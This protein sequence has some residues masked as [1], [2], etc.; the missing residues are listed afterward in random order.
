MIDDPGGAARPRGECAESRLERVLR[1]GAFAVTAETVP[2]LS[3]DANAVLEVAAPLR[4]LVDAVN[5]T[6]GAGARV[7]LSALAAAAILAREGIEPVLQFTCRD[8]NRLALQADLL[9]AAALGVR[10]VLCLR[11]DDPSAGDQP[12]AKAVFDLDSAELIATAAAMR[13]AGR[14]PSGRAIEAPPRFFIGAVDT[15]IDP[16]PDWSPDSLRNKLDRGADFVQTQLCFD[17]HVIER[18]IGRLRDEGLTERLFILVGL[19]PISSARSARW[20]RERLWGVRIPDAVVERLEHTADPKAEGRR[21]CVELIRRLTELP[22]VSGVHVM[23]PHDRK[24]VPAV[25]EEAGLSGLR[26]AAP[27]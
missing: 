16:A 27:R 21:I 7:H 5:V 18:Y 17:F 10:N 23:A 4:R 26:A 3:G 19:G 8:R 13:D 2:P 9:G 20:M 1:A 24:D 11:G 14:L 6:D 12:E 15:P 25:I 22:G